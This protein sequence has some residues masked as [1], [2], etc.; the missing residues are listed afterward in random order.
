MHDLGGKLR[1]ALRMATFIF[2]LSTFILITS[3]SDDMPASQADAALHVTS[4][5][6]DGAQAGTRAV[7]EETATYDCPYN[8]TVTGFT[9]GDKLELHYTF[10]NWTSRETAYLTRTADGWEVNNIAGQPLDVRPGDGEKWE[11]FGATVI[12]SHGGMGNDNDAINDSSSG[13]V[14][15]DI[16]TNDIMILRDKLTASTAD[17]TIVVDTDINSPTLGAISIKLGRVDQAMLRLPEAGASIATGT[18]LVGGKEYTNP[19]LGTLWAVVNDG[20][21]DK[22][23][24]LTSVTI[25]EIEYL[26][27]FVLAY[28]S[29][30]KGFKAVMQCGTGESAETFTLD[31]PFSTDSSTDSSLTL[32]PGTRYPLT[33]N[34][35]PTRST[36]TLTGTD[37]KPSWGE[38]GNI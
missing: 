10:D 15:G 1:S 38:E 35:S 11:D 25:D 29:T 22:Y 13:I 36:V 31:L 18:Y 21:A 34:I 7:Y 23:S 16:P 8:R 24:P 28:N 14:Q 6:I 3:C 2:H 9:E 4:V 26:Q 20:S 19:T 32:K 5:T 17:N 30:L 12:L 37:S 27:A 33:L